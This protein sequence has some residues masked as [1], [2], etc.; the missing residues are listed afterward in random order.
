MPNVSLVTTT[1]R[2][3]PAHLAGFDGLTGRMVYARL[4][5]IRPG[6]M[7]NNQ[8]YAL[9]LRRLISPSHAMI[10]ECERSGCVKDVV[11]QD[12]AER[13]GSFWMAVDEMFMRE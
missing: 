4:A 5:C 12:W 13:V 1:N 7:V 2:G 11:S 9:Q 6:N 8:K 10:D 3:L